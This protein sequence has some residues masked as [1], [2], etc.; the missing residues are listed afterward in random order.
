MDTGV[1]DTITDCNYASSCWESSIFK[2][3]TVCA[4]YPPL[5]PRLQLSANMPPQ[6]IADIIMD[7]KQQRRAVDEKR[8]SVLGT[9]NMT[10][11]EDNEVVHADETSG[12]LL[13]K[14]KA[15]TEIGRP[16][17][18]FARLFVGNVVPNPMCS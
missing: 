13:K 15:E 6:M 1:A 17:A 11:D 3:N 14:R 7:L 5:Y 8:A 2:M 4:E 10:D 12:H 9:L 18:E 16:V